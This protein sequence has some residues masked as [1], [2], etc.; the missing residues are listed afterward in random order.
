MLPNRVGWCERNADVIATER[1]IRTSL[2]LKEVQKKGNVTVEL[3]DRILEW[4]DM[5]CTECHASLKGKGPQV[6]DEHEVKV[7]ENRD[8]SDDDP[9]PAT[10]TK[11]TEDSDPCEEDPR[12][13]RHS[14]GPDGLQFPMDDV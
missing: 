2:I 12:K 9:E 13:K 6:L 10:H 8:L 11:D 1:D 14:W 7:C 3:T 4:N 5:K